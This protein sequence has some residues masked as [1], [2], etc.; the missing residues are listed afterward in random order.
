MYKDIA[1]HEYRNGR[2]G[3]N[4]A[5]FVRTKGGYLVG[6]GFGDP[7]FYAN[8]VAAKAAWREVIRIYP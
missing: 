1:I 5:A 3:T 6:N 8:P 2:F 7:F 4:R